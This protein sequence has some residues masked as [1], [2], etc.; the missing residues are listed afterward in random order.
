MKKRPIIFILLCFTMVA[1]SAQSLAEARTMFTKGEYDKAKPVFERYVKSRSSN[2]NYNYWYGVCC[3]KT[4]EAAKAVKHLKFATKRKVPKAP[5]YLANAY[6]D[7]YRF[8]EAVNSYQQYIDFLQKKKKSTEEAEELL[9]EA[10]LN[11]RMIKG[12]EDVCIIDSFV[13]NKK[14]FLNYYKISQESGKLFTYNNYFGKQEKSESTVYETQIGNKIYY[15]ET[16]KDGKLDIFTKNKMPNKWG[17]RVALPENINGTGNANYPYVLTD[18][19]TIYFA[20]DG[21]GSIGGYDIFVTRYNTNTNTYLTSDNIG[22]PFNSPYNDYMYVIDEYNNLGWFASDRYQPQGKVC[23]YVFIPNSSKQIYNYEA[24][25]PEL[26]R[27]L[28]QLHSLKETWKDT[29]RVN[30]AIARLKSVINE[31]PEIRETYDFEF[32]INDELTYHS[33]DQFK[34]SKAKELFRRYKQK[35]NDYQEQKEKLSKQRELYAEANKTERLKMS[36]AILDLEKRVEEMGTEVKQLAIS[37][38]NTEIM[39]LKK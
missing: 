33:I 32:I 8:D 39:Y 35:S 11:A 38:R 15:S 9:K 2:A 5:L 28:A 14:D 30:N 16:G 10:K 17:E 1:A 12:V 27:R 7:L 37:T 4:G 19:Q 34:S 13:V 22:M 25:D 24:T 20:S 36:P 29:K 23:I 21:K 31:R 26:M 6:N 18:G 3:V